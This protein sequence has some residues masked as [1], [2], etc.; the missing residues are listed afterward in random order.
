MNLVPRDK[1]L[2]TVLNDSKCFESMAY[3]YRY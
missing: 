3:Y 2:G 1:L